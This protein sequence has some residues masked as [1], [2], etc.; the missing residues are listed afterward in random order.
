ML[1][2]ARAA[3]ARDLLIALISGGASALLPAPAPPL[4]L[5]GKQ[6]LTR[7]SARLRRDHP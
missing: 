1:E 4:T 2:M 5:E 3:G 6:Q 7:A